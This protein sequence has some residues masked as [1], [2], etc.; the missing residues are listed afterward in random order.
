M[1]ITIDT[2]E[3]LSNLDILLLRQLLGDEPPVADVSPAKPKAAAKPAAA[4]EADEDLLGGGDAPTMDQ[5]VAL[6]TSLVGDGQTAK[7]KAVLTDLGIK[8]VT[9]LSEDQIAGFIEALS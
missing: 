8:K 1:Q 3:D 2:G 4:P 6:A 9:E 5:A 7:V